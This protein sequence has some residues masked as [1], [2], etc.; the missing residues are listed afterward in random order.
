MHAS[1]AGRALLRVIA[2]MTMIGGFAA[3]WNRTHLFN[4]RWPPHAKF[5]D[6]MTIC[7]AFFLGG[8]GL[9]LLR[10]AAI[11]KASLA[12]GALLP[13]IFW[14]S[15]MLSFAFPNTGGLDAEFPELIPRVGSLALNELPFS[16]LLVFFTAVGFVLSRQEYPR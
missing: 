10:R 13:G 3:D 12:L 11:D 2:T 14:F 9:L 7:L 16:I 8:I 1:K 5:H 15:Q 6:A 4:A